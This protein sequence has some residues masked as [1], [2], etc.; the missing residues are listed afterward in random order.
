MFSSPLSTLKPAASTATH[1]AAAEADLRRARRETYVEPLRRKNRTFTKQEMDNFK[2]FISEFYRTIY[3][4]REECNSICEKYS[5]S[6]GKYYKELVADQ[7]EIS[8]EDFWQRYFYRCDHEQINNERNRMSFADP[9]PMNAL[10]NQMMKSMN[11]SV[12]GVTKLIKNAVDVVQEEFSKADLEVSKMAES[13]KDA[14]NAEDK[15]VGLKKKEG[16]NSSI[17]MPT[18]SEGK[19]RKNSN[20]GATGKE[21]TEAPL[22]SSR[23]RDSTPN[24]RGNV[25]RSGSNCSE[26]SDSSRFDPALFSPATSL[27]KTAAT[28]EAHLRRGRK[29]TYLEPLRNDKKDYSDSDLDDLNAFLIDFHQTIDA[30][31]QELS[32]IQHKYPR[33]VA[34][35]YDE[36]VQNGSVSTEEFW[37]RYFYRCDPERIMQEWNRQQ[38]SHRD[39]LNLSVRKSLADAKSL[40]QSAIFGVPS[41]AG[42]N[43]SR[44]MLVNNN[45][46]N[47]DLLEEYEG[48]DPSV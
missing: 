41:P 15:A 16:S 1:S 9:N 25:K 42:K 24:R 36:L 48:D 5:D 12:H 30:R 34:R 39:T 10:E 2:T 32:V 8:Y 3:K 33:T 38:V 21:D 7:K 19:G 35:F 23:H 11:D 45:T 44:Q 14:K 22:S 26:E 4:R 37:Q 20:K 40:F 13:A 43:S 6:V 29:T 47:T 28:S 46:N 31:M 27:K 18:I 17:N